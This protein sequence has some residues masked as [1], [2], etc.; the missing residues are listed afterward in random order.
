[1]S[2]GKRGRNQINAAQQALRGGSAI[3]AGLALATSGCNR[4]EALDAF[5]S[6][7]SDQLQAGIQAISTGVINGAF[8]AFDLK[9]GDSGSANTSG[10]DAV[11][12]T[13]STNTATTP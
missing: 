2:Y 6:G 12:T 8:A 3:L 4:D 9:S 5:R 10:A 1:M 7:A 11:T 13:D